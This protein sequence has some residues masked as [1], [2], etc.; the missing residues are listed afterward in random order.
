MSE[1]L[2]RGFIMLL[3]FF[4]TGPVL[5]VVGAELRDPMRP[6]AGYRVYAPVKDK[7]SEEKANWV[8]QSVLLGEER[9]VAVIDGV[10]ISQDERYLGARLLRV[11]ADRVE[12]QTR[13][14]KEIVLL[15]TPGI[16]KRVSAYM[17]KKS[18]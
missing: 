18:K 1:S 14:G 15:L 8:L 10:S 7:V 9:A 3:L 12:L 11:K 5:S 16:T 2:R 17:E 6:P 4:L 13:S